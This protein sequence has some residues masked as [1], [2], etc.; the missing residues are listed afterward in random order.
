M[1]QIEQQMSEQFSTRVRLRTD[2]TGKR[3]SMTLDF[4]DLDHFE[5]LV[6]KM[7]VR[8]DL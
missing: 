7:G 8:L 4:Y 5:G 6:R 3:G 1:R 2:K